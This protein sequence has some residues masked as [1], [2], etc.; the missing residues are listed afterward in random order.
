MGYEQ[1][2]QALSLSL[3]LSNPFLFVINSKP[4]ILPSILDLQESSPPTIF[5]KFPDHHLSNPQTIAP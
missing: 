5:T 3:S 2:K 4:T 1:T